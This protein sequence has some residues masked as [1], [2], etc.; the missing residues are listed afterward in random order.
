MIT[1]KD[2]K[3]DYFKYSLPPIYINGFNGGK[4]DVFALG[5]ILFNLLTAKHSFTFPDKF[6]QSYKFI[7]IHSYDNF[8]KQQNLN[9]VLNE[10][11][12]KLFV[13]MIKPNPEKRI[14]IDDIEEFQWIKDFKDKSD[15]EKKDIE[16]KLYEEFLKR[17]K[18]IK[19][20][21]QKTIKKD[22]YNDDLG[23]GNKSSGGR[24]SFQQL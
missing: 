8:W 9:I 18:K 14:K 17:E 16:I 10:N 7:L 3:K 23:Y 4:A 20:L 13:K 6:D 11:F 15:N 5:V 21:T 22:S 19:A 1:S 24:R 12:K 2:Y